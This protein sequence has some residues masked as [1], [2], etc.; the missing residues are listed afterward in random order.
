MSAPTTLPLHAALRAASRGR[1]SLPPLP[2]LPSRSPLPPIPVAKHPVPP[3][4]LALLHD[5]PSL[6]LR[7]RY[8]MDG[9]LMGMHRSPKKGYSVE[10]A[11]YR[12]YQLGDDLRRIDWRLY[13]RSDRLNVKQYEQETQ[14]RVFLVLD[15]S[16]S[17]AYTSRSESWLRKIDFARTLLA[18]VGL[19]ALRQCDAF[20]LAIIGADL[21]DYLKPKASKAHWQ[22]ALG[23][24][25]AMQTGGATGLAKGLSTLA[26]L[27]PR[28]SLIVIASDFYEESVALNA[29]LRRLRFDR[30]EIIAFHTLDPVEIDLNEDWSGTFIDAETGQRQILDSVAVR[31]GYVDRIQK[32]L[33]QTQTSFLDHAGDYSLLRTDANPMKALGNYLGRRERLC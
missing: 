11:E 31:R 25:D 15:T 18:A 32:F 10:F 24:M 19:L 7:A 16:A 27:L 23:R 33:A 22:T 26:E 2:P 28:R 12:P 20:G 6:E 3:L 1:S 9:Y 17:M 30:Q 8:L 21:D 29:A 14:L 4:D 5:L 13:G